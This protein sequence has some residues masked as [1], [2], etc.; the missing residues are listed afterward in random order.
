MD[1]CLEKGIEA[2]VF[3]SDVPDLL[4]QRLCSDIISDEPSLRLLYTTPESLQQPRLRDA[5]KVRTTH[6]LAASPAAATRPPRRP[7]PPPR[8]PPLSPRAQV[9]SE[10]GTLL[11]FA[12]DEAHCV[13]EWGSDFR[14]VR[15]C[16]YV[17][18]RGGGTLSTHAREGHLRVCACA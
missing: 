16:C 4:K 14:P 6:T 10:Q 18:S 17:S 11:T 15:R 8:A 13:C 1:K 7:A 12:I 5:L 2:A 3:N 9:A